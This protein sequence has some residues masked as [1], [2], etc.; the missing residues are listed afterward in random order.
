[1]HE[2]QTDAPD[3]LLEQ[4]RDLSLSQRVH[5][6][7]GRVLRRYEFHAVYELVQFLKRTR[8]NKTTIVHVK[9]DT[10]NDDNDYDDEIVM[11]IITV[12]LGQ[13]KPTNFKRFSITIS[14]LFSSVGTT[15]GTF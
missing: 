9:I 13:V 6:L 12:G 10:D 11:M 14:V 3:A 4:R 2:R 7:L 5:Q 1:M 15:K 8:A